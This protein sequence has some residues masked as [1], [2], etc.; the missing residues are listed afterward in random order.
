MQCAVQS[1]A[2]LRARRQTAA[3]TYG[4][5]YAEMRAELERHL[6]HMPPQ[7]DRFV[8]IVTSEVRLQEALSQGALLHDVLNV[9]EQRYPHPGQR[10]H[11]LRQ[12]ANVAGTAQLQAALN[13]IAVHHG[14]QPAI[15]VEPSSMS[16]QPSLS[17]QYS[18]PA[19]HQPSLS[20]R[21]S[22][23]QPLYHP[24]AQREPMPVDDPTVVARRNEAIR[25]LSTCLDRS[26]NRNLALEL[27]LSIGLLGDLDRTCDSTREAIVRMLT[28]YFSAPRLHRGDQIQTL[29][30]ALRD[31]SL[32]M[33][34]D[35]LVNRMAW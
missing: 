13:N 14:I 22:L 35:Q 16:A 20:I 12:I 8:A 10:I 31:I 32:N 25:F 30:R 26:Q 5:A 24:S 4:Q 21:Q 9:M 33:T 15:P 19:A 27:G 18:Y 28:E 6:Q 11:V 3:G 34:A 7:V 1:Y 2:S 23:P 29:V 17:T